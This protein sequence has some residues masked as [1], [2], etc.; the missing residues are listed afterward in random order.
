MRVGLPCSSALICATTV[1]TDAGTALPH[2][3]THIEFQDR[4][5][6]IED[7]DCMSLFKDLISLTRKQLLTGPYFVSLVPTFAVS[8]VCSRLLRYILWLTV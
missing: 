2:D 1:I 8:V 7:D 3:R 4:S 5:I 6:G